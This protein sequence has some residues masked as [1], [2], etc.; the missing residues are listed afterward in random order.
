MRLTRDLNREGKARNA[1]F[2]IVV[3]G[4]ETQVFFVE[5]GTKCIIL[6]SFVKKKRIIHFG[7]FYGFLSWGPCMKNDSFYVIIC[8]VGLQG[9][10][11]EKKDPRV[12]GRHSIILREHQNSVLCVFK[13]CSQELF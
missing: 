5:C 7:E 10:R 9:K 13:K 3:Y 1:L 6:C 11:G 8:S 2:V 4:L 12:L